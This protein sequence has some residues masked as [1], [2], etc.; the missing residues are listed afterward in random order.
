MGYSV[1]ISHNSDD[2]EL[3]EKIEQSLYRNN[4]RPYIFEY[5]PKPGESLTNKIEEAISN[6]DA[7]VVL[8]TNQ[9]QFSKWVNA[10]IGYAKAQEVPIIPLVDKNITNPDIPFIGDTEYIKIDI[11]NI[12]DSLPVLVKDLSKR[13]WKKRYF[14]GTIAVGVAVLYIKNKLKKKYK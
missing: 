11:K 8:V 2:K 7:F 6:S 10:E 5:D 4:I 3:V 13:R 9:G 14:W 12:G 1:F